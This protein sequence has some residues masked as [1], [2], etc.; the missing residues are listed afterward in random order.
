MKLVAH[1]AHREIDIEVLG[2]RLTVNKPNEY[3]RETFPTQGT[4]KLF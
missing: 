4:V 3:Y 1:P 2:I